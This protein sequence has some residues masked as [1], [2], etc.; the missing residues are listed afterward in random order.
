MHIDMD[1]FFASVEQQDNPEFR[2]KPVIVGADP[3]NGKGRGVVSAASYEARKYNVHSAL[4]I[5]QAFRRCPHGIFLPVRGDRYAQVS[6]NIMSIFQ[7]YTPYVE[8]VSLDE[9]FLD[10]TGL[11][12]L[13]GNIEN[14]GR[15]LKAEIKKKEGLT[16]SVGIAPNKWIAKIASDMEKPDG[17]VVVRYDQV[18]SF[19]DPLPV[20]KLW[21]VGKKTAEKLKSLNIHTVGD[22]AKFPLSTLVDHFGKMGKFLHAYANGRDESPVQPTR[23]VKSVSNEKTF[24][25]DVTDREII[26]ETL[27][28][29][30]EKVGYRLRKKK[31]TGK[32]IS[33]KVRY[34]D[35]STCIRHISIADPTSMSQVIFSECWN[36]FKAMYADPLPVRLVGVGVSNLFSENSSQID[37]FGETCEKYKILNRALDDLKNR[38]GES[39]IQKGRIPRKRN[40]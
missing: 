18:R 36:L 24:K 1:A 28:A 21:G 15:K 8:P 13:W 39:V 14:L 26:K 30:A 35:F 31:L 33:I 40:F 9:A 10:F 7:T 27:L 37:L 5:S 25:K 29:L 20:E 34:A 4:P 12:R 19:L 2:G 16:A 17:F 11:Q 6:R 22:L 32:T 23:D 38:F 3:E